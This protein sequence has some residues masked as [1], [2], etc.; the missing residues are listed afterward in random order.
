VTA[1]KKVALPEWLATA[2]PA[3]RLRL[4]TPGEV[5]AMGLLPYKSERTLKDAC[6]RRQVPHTKVAGKIRMNLEHIW[7]T[8]Q[9]G[10]VD[11]ATRGRRRAA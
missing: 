10:D 8:Q 3:D 1:A 11:P 9:A 5:V 7:R 2:A 6:Y 4:Y